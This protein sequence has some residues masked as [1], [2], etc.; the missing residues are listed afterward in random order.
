MV[1][2]YNIQNSFKSEVERSMRIAIH[3]TKQTF[4]NN[5][6]LEAPRLSSLRP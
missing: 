3:G 4:K 6:T 5:R 2:P 1:Y